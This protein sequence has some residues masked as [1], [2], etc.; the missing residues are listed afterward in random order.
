MSMS[1]YNTALPSS[2]TL[3]CG[4]GGYINLTKSPD[5]LPV[6][7]WD[8]GRQYGGSPVKN[9]AAISLNSPHIFTI[10]VFFLFILQAFAL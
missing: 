10:V 9:N 7:F 2:D 6:H 3:P 4:L 5:L 8:C 1:I